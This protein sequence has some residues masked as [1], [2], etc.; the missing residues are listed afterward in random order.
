MTDTHQPEN[1]MRMLKLS[2]MVD[3][4]DTRLNQAQKDGLGFREF[5]E[6]LLEILIVFIFNMMDKGDAID[7]GLATYYN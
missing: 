7:P 3:T 6:L 2:G 4:L 1:K 5:L